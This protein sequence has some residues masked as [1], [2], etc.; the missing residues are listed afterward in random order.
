MFVPIV[1]V[2]R[3]AKEERN[4]N[5]RN[6]KTIANAC[7]EKDA[8]SI[9]DLWVPE[10][11]HDCT[12]WEIVGD[13]FA[14]NYWSMHPVDGSPGCSLKSIPSGKT[15]KTD[16]VIDNRHYEEEKTEKQVPFS[17]SRVTVSSI[18]SW[19]VMKCNKNKLPNQSFICIWLQLQIDCAVLF[20]WCRTETY[21][22]K[23]DSIN[24]ADN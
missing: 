23:N 4:D 1:K 12:D 16:G 24:Q 20:S 19:F 7:A 2:G 13:T 21:I 18:D 17:S 10:L 6:C 22:F 9:W 5:Q 8:G 14:D 3:G 11:T 15:L